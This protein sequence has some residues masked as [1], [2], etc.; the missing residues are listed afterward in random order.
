MLISFVSA[1]GSPGV[2]TTALAIGAVWPR[3][4]VVADV[5]PFG[6]DVAA[7]LGRGSWP[8]GAGLMELVLDARTMPVEAALPQRVFR[9]A[10]HCPYALAGFGQPGQAGGMPWREVADAFARSTDVDVLADCG[11]FTPTDGVVPLLRRSDVL[12]LV[13]RST[14][15]AVRA[16]ARLAPLLRALGPAEPGDPRLTV[17]MV[18]P[19]RPYSGAE[20]AG[21]C[22][23]PLLGE[24]PYDPRT[25][26][27]WSDGSPP[28]RGLTRTPLQRQARRAAELLS[29][30]SARPTAVTG[31]AR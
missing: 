28:G 30:T 12:V 8:A 14:L 3:R 24:L 29:G 1:K 11:R 5:D 16:A 13:T 22:E 17:L 6:G 2:T 26:A 27:V 25:A 31:G 21:A 7:G 10:A 20:I 9:P 4:A 19:D 18:A 23:A 15:P